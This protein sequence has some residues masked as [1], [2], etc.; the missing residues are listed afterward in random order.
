MPR[1]PSPRIEEAQIR[2]TGLATADIWLR[3]MTALHWQ[4]LV[5][6]MAVLL[7]YRLSAGVVLIYSN[8]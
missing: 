7:L 3:E 6:M 5:E 2:S 8:P 1:G 4:K